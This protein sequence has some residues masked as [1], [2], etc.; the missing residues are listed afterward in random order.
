MK[1]YTFK[2]YSHNAHAVRS[3][4]EL[5]EQTGGW[6]AHPRPMRNI[7]RIGSAR[8]PSVPPSVSLLVG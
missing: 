2:H 7:L 4:W 1:K 5:R 6:L 8:Q 3:Q